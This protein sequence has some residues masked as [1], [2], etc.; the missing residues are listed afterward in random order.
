LGYN[1]SLK[2]KK[3]L[4][5]CGP[6][7]VPIDSVRVI[8]NTSSGELAHII[9]KNLSHE[10]AKVT[11]LQGPVTHPFLCPRLKIISFE[12]F[13]ELAKLLTHELKK[14]H[15]DI[16]IHAAA[17]SDYQLKKASPI[18]MSS[19][20]KSLH[21]DLTPTQKLISKIKKISPKS[22]LV[23][24]KLETKTNKRNLLKKAQQLLKDAH[25]N[26]V[27]ANILN[28]KSYKAYIV[29]KKGSMIAK[30]NSRKEIALK[31]TKTLKG[32]L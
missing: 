21:L 3:V 9:A 22:F 23:G 1:G 24:F 31:L 16:V 15:Y 6:T 32:Q 25:C 2:N 17:V 8:S 28:K 4:I 18:K 19:H 13:D 20:L 11:L 10:Q 27:I 14:N 5:T 7:W 26:L 30:A 29:N 12:Y